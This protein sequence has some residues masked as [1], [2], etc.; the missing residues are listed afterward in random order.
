MS[1]KVALN[2]KFLDDVN[3]DN[4]HN[5]NGDNAYATKC[6]ES[7]VKATNGLIELNEY[8]MKEAIGFV[9]KDVSQVNENDMKAWSVYMVYYYKQMKKKDSFLESCSKHFYKTSKLGLDIVR[10]PPPSY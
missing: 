7:A 6:Y 8:I 10:T 5:D 1:D 9:D 3:I 4:D 2:L